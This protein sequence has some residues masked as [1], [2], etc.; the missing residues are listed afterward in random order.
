MPQQELEMILARQLASYLAIPLCI[1]DPQG[2]LLFYNEPV[3]R[4][5]GVRFEETGKMSAAEWASLFTPKSE[6]DVPLEPEALPHMI[7]LAE[8]RPAYSRFRIEGLDQVRRCLEVTAFPLL[9]QAR[10]NL[11]AVVLFWEVHE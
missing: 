2:T 9:G 5:L 1:M 3:E 6:H 10:R 7:A 4:I 11:G 8:Q